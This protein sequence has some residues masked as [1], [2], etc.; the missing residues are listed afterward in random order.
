MRVEGLPRRHFWSQFVRQAGLTG[1][2]VERGL[3]FDTEI[4]TVQYVLS[5]SGIAL[6]DL[7]RSAITSPPVG[8]SSLTTRR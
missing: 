8:S 5:G 6:I 7:D 2:D 3:V 4:L 1:L